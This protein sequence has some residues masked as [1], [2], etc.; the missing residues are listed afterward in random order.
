MTQV[1]AEL[2]YDTGPPGFYLDEDE[3]ERFSR[4]SPI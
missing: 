3:Y 2:D 4:I 1:D